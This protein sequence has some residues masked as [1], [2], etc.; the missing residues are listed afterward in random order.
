ME[1][2]YVT[3]I[4]MALAMDAFGVTLVIGLNSSVK[5][6]HKIKFIASFAFFQF[7]FAYFGSVMGHLFDIYI[8]NIP[9]LAGG[10]IMSI[11]GIIMIMDGLNE[12]E[13][14]VLVKNS[15]CVILGI[16][17]SID[18]LVIG[19]TAF[20]SLGMSIVM[21]VNS[22]FIGLVT[23]FMCTCGFIICNYIKKIEFIKK[24]ANFFGGIALI[25][26]G[27]KMIFG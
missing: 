3:L 7:F 15:T 10:I 5:R 18:A 27:L 12:K 26:F 9:S 20:H 25:L 23:A 8:T 22:I 24:Y 2:R 21:F 4:A 17:V 16:S 13:N 14:E 6:I 19:F 1:F 11:I